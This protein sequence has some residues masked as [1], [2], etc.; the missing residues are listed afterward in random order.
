[1]V[2]LYGEESKETWVPPQKIVEDKTFFNFTKWSPTFVKVLT[3]KRLDLRKGMAES[4]GS[5]DVPIIAEIMEKRQAA[6]D[7]AV[8]R[9]V[10]VEDDVEIASKPKK[11]KVKLRAAAKHAHLAPPILEINVQGR[12]LMV[13]FDGLGTTSIWLEMKEDTLQWLQEQVAVSSPESRKMIQ[14]KRKPADGVDQDCSEE[15]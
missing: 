7:E 9:A 5:I 11:K 2:V 4:S 6:A 3:G 10:D 1:M 8:Q 15:E 12:P 13:L 14:A